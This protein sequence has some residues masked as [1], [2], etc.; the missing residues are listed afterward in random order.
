MTGVPVI[1]TF[2]PLLRHPSGVGTGDPSFGLRRISPLDVAGPVAAQS[3]FAVTTYHYDA[4]RTGWNNHE[5]ILTATSFPGS[6]GMLKTVALDDQVDAQ[7]LLVPGLTITAGPFAG[8]THDVVYVA[9]ESNTIY[10]IDAKTVPK[11][12]NAIKVDSTP[13]TQWYSG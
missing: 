8:S 1:P 9:T 5:T 13:E 3:P 4:L 12:T 2:G 11:N 6:F 7:P 10:A